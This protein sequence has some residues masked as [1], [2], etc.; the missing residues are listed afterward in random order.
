MRNM[1]I[2]PFFKSFLGGATGTALIVAVAF[3]IALTN[4][5]QE[6]ETTSPPGVVNEY[7][8]IPAHQ[9]AY[10]PEATTD[11]RKAAQKSLDAVVHIKTEIVSA[12]SSYHEFFGPFKDYFHPYPDR[13][14]VYT[15]FGSGVIISANGYIVTN[16]HVVNGSDKI[17]VKFNDGQ[18][19]EATIVG[20]DPTTDLALIKVEKQNLPYLNYGDSDELQVGD[21][22][23]AVGNPFNLTSTV[24]AG[25]VSAKARNINIL[26]S[27][28]AIE[29][30][31]QTDA[32]VNKG[33]SG[34]ALVNTSGDLVGINAAIASH[35]GVYEGYSFAIPVNIVKKVVDDLME[36]GEIQRA[37][38]GVQIQDMNAE[39]A[40]KI[41]T[42]QVTGV[43]I[44]GVIENSGAEEAGLQV[45]D[46]I[47][48]VDG[49]P[50]PTLS[51]LMGVIAQYRPGSSV[52][53][54]INRNNNT[55][56]KSVVLKNENGT[57][58]IVNSSE[59]FYNELLAA[60][61][62]QIELEDRE[63]LRISG[64]LKVVEVD[65]G[66]LRQGGINKG[67]ILYEVN[68]MKIHSQQ[69]LDEALNKSN[70]VIRLKGMYPNGAKI[71][72]EFMK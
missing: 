68:G 3:Y 61:L 37:Y 50:T 24:T 23:L 44:A 4:Q 18:E 6:S 71:S 55:S 38:I 64:G 2:S 65:S 12:S 42:D 32:A 45:G 69:N 34:G 9:A 46:I 29:S 40:D 57:T 72:Y 51:S 52:N 70:N 62:Q 49:K 39:L 47:L 26:G 15:A 25:I 28:S 48:S 33:N 7:E 21:W 16:N 1:R 53:V 8:H 14:N 31:I 13:K 43:Y 54:V 17:S 20:L 22:V 11:F 10:L 60:K 30:F 27:R 36:Y 67:F 35:T 58:A 63:K 5:Q 19:A 41:G 59:A 66:I 56:T